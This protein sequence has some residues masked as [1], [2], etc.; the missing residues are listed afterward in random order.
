MFFSG[1]IQVSYIKVFTYYRVVE[2]IDRGYNHTLIGTDDMIF[3]YFPV[4]IFFYFQF[5]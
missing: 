4:N 3:P 5:A 2:F 1:W